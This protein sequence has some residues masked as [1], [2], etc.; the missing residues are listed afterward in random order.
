MAKHVFNLNNLVVYYLLDCRGIFWWTLL[1][2]YPDLIESFWK[3]N[4]CRYQLVLWLTETQ[5]IHSLS[6]NTYISSWRLA[7]IPGSLSPSWNSCY[8][9]AGLA[10]DSHTSGLA[11]AGDHSRGSYFGSAPKHCLLCFMKGDR[12]SNPW[13]LIPII[14]YPKI[15]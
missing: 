11:R 10:W 6:S 7:I 2:R 14:L 15:L 9:Q 5:R 13:H 8:P 12:C 3:F 1:L 4:A